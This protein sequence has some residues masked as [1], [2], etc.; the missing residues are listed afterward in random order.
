M[1][2][3]VLATFFTMFAAFLFGVMASFL[4]LLSSAAAAAT[5]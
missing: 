4:A 3:L 2:L 5:T 1:T